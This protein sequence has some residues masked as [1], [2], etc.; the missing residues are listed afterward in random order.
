MQAGKDKGF[1]SATTYKRIRAKNRQNQAFSE[2][3]GLIFELDDLLHL[4]GL[5]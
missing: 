1:I 4:Q 5:Y 3:N 2:K